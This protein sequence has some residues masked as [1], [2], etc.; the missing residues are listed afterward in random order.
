MSSNLEPMLTIEPDG[1]MKFIYQDEL[2]DMLD[3]GEP[4]VQRVSHVEPCQGGSWLADLSPVLGPLLGPFRL[5]RD[6]LAA[7]IEWLRANGF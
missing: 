2:A 7:E 1:T 5:R 3:L 4:C 6:A